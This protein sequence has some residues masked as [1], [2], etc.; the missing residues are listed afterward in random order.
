MTE[1]AMAKVATDHAEH[2]ARMRKALEVLEA[3]ERLREIN[4]AE[5]N[6]Q[7]G[8]DGLFTMGPR[9]IPIALR[10]FVELAIKLSESQ[11]HVDAHAAGIRERRVA[12]DTAAAG[13]GPAVGIPGV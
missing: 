10:T 13:H 1:K 3:V 7:P 12:C 4:D 5:R 8:P 9:T 2:L 11:R 6:P